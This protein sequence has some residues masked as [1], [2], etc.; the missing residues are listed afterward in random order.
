MSSPTGRR[1]C[2]SPGDCARRR[3]ANCGGGGTRRARNGARANPIEADLSSGLTTWPL[4]DLG[5][6]RLAPGLP[7]MAT[8]LRAASTPVARAEARAADGART[9]WLAGCGGAPGAREPLVPRTLEHHA[10]GQ[11][12]TRSAGKSGKGRPT[13]PASLPGSRAP[14]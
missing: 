8:G 10:P 11:G 13:P 9:G 12:L 4:A 1:R 2:G 7:V 3:G 5:A 6:P 14:R